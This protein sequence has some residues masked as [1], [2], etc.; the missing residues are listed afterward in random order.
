MATTEQ[1]EL[2]FQKLDKTQPA[3]F[4]K[5]ADEVQV[6]IGAVLKLLIESSQPLTA[7]EISENLNISTARVAV[8]LKKMVGKGLVTKEHG[9]LDA[10]ITIVKL[11]DLGEETI[12]KM[13][14]EM[15]HV[16]GQ[17]ID[18]VGLDRLLDFFEIADEIRNVTDSPEFRF[19]IGKI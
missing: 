15:Y 16:M 10:R 12:K 8:L 6:G 1:I 2:M 19:K 17:V 4:F 13:K 5:Y 9:L 11:T 3:T 14:E 18:V 7:G